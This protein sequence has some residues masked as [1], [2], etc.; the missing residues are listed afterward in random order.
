MLVSIGGGKE[1]VWSRSG[2]ELFSRNGSQMFGVPI[3]TE[4]ALRAGK[5][6]LLFEGAYTYGY[7]DW[8]FNDDVAADGR[9]LMV[10]EGPVPKLQ[11][12]VNW[13]EEL[14]RLVPAN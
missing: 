3:T 2:R 10:R 1:P 9:F 6:T 13:F 14:R 7:L 12:V 8:S 11:V 5:P 4:P